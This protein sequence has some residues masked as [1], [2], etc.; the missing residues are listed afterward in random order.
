MRTNVL[1]DTSVILEGMD[2]VEGIYDDDC[3]I[4]VTDIVLQELD[5]KKSDEKVGFNARSFFRALGGAE[6]KKM[7]KIPVSLKPLENGDT[8]FMMP[9][10]TESRKI[11]LYVLVRK[12]CKTRD[13][14]DSKIIEVAKDYGLKLVTFDTAQKVRAMSE[15]VDAV[16]G[17][18]IEGVKAARKRAIRKEIEDFESKLLFNI[19][20]RKYSSDEEKIEEIRKIK[21]RFNSNNFASS[22]RI[23]EPDTDH[24]RDEINGIIDYGYGLYD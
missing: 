5:G 19:F 3:N 1:L 2:V 14:N 10:S 20:P 18:E 7:E 6:G 8:L 4:F 11:P 15:G 23:G 9:L 24:I 13:I 17:D 12:R 16:L 21:A 22:K